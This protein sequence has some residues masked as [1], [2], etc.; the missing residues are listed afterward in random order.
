M[1]TYRLTT[2]EQ[3]CFRYEIAGLV[4]R[5]MAHLADQTL[6]WLLRIAIAIALLKWGTELG[7][8]IMLLGIFLLDFGYFVFFELYWAGQSPG[9]R[10]L[11]IRVM[12]SRGGRLTFADVL[13][14][15]LLR[16]LDSLPILMAI[17]GPVALIDPLRRRLGDLAAD[18]IV[19][20]D[21]RVALPTAMLEQRT[22]VNTFA[23]DPAIRNR[24]LLRVTAQER[25][26]I[27]GLMLRRDEL[28]PAS[29]EALFADAAR[30]FRTRFAL[31][32]DM[33]FLSDEQTVVN[34][35]LVIQG[36]KF[37]A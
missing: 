16:P 32:E 11:K 1:P 4:T 6:L 34:L 30:H 23:S 33:D 3:V 31:P 27:L 12:S 18:T 36:A 17:G 26:L 14:R 29:R 19:V 20:R 8:A 13:M 5:A 35:G 22:R 28:E 37:T 9:K 7:V 10:M 25:D 2:P 15:N 21:V 24:V